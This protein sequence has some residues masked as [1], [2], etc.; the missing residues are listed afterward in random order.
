VPFNTSLHLFSFPNRIRR[1]KG[2]KNPPFLV[3]C[4]EK[5]TKMK[6]AKRKMCEVENTASDGEEMT[7]K[8][9]A[10]KEDKEWNDDESTGEDSTNE[11]PTVEETTDKFRHADSER[12]L[13]MISNQDFD[14]NHTVGKY[15][16]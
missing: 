7:D 4:K 1:K 5:K 9:S 10:D 15:T 8:E 14:P 16:R 3:W 12:R 6:S 2:K 13:K 11:E